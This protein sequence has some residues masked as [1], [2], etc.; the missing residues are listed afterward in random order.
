MVRRGNHG[1]V[2]MLLLPH[3]H[4]VE[5]KFILSRKFSTTKLVLKEASGVYLTLLDALAERGSSVTSSSRAPRNAVLESIFYVEKR[6]MLLCL[7][8][9]VWF[10][11][12]YSSQEQ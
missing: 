12:L 11:C 9:L 10:V 2:I 5:L 6:A 1:R 8:S 3:I 7:C 4:D